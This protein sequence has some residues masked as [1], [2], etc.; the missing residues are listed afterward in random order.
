MGN[1]H[2]KTQFDRARDELCSH[3][4]RCEVL[5][6]HM[7][8]R[9]EWLSE[10]MDYMA[11]RY[12]DLTELEIAQLEVIGRRFVQPAIPHGAKSHG[13]NR[14]RWQEPEAEET[15]AGAAEVTE[16]TEAAEA[17]KADEP[18]LAVV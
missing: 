6:A 5:D 13:A 11:D 18:V 3:V 9:F 4:I 17:T 7:E 16:A 12:P 14:D 10:T 2:R 8:D 15:Q 1:D